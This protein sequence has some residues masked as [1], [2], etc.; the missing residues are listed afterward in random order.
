[1]TLSE[2]ATNEIV[3]RWPEYKQRN[4]GIAYDFYGSLTTW[5]ESDFFV[6]IIFALCLR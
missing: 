2:G 4:V 3:T 5:L 1:M 6:F